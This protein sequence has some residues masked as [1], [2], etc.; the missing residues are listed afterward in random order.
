[1]RSYAG[2]GVASSP[3]M[4]IYGEGSRKEAYV[5]L[6]DGRSI[7]VAMSGGGGGGMEVHIHESPGSKA[8]VSKTQNANGRPQ[9]HVE[10]RDMVRGVMNEDIANSGPMSRSMEKQY[11]LRR[12]AG[13]TS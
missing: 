5:P 9:L 12:S 2:G 3:Q 8:S 6:P 11:G 7:P 13:L 10:I 4:A 1:M